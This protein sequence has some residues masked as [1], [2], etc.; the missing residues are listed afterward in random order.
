M[1]GVPL[2]NGLEAGEEARTGVGLTRRGLLC[3][4][5]LGAG[6]KPR[7][8]SEGAEMLAGVMGVAPTATAYPEPLT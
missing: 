5:G 7:S 3:L 6:S 2:R 8:A 4:K 1:A